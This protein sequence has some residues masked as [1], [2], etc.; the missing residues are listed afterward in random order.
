MWILNTGLPN[1]RLSVAETIK[2]RENNLED[3]SKTVT[4]R[5]GI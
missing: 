1:A 3:V 2:S 5:E 4:I